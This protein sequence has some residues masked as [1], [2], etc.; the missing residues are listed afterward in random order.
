MTNIKET[1]SD[2]KPITREELINIMSNEDTDWNGDNA[3]QGLQ[4][5]SKYSDNLIIAAEHDIIYSVD[6]DDV[7]EK[8]ITKEDAIALRKLNWMIESDVDCLACF[9]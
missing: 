7:I 5:L 1:Y 4:I 8:G 6:V 9:I 3:F 2:S